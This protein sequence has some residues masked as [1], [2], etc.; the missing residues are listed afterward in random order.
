MPVDPAVVNALSDT[1]LYQEAMAFLHE[2]ANF[3]DGSKMSNSQLVGLLTYSRNWA[4]LMAY[5]KHQVGR[6]WV[7]KAHYALFYRSLLKYLDTPP[8][9]LRM[10][11]K[12]D[13]NLLVKGL[14]RKEER[15]QIYPWA[16]ALAQEFM[17]HLVAQA[18]FQA[19]TNRGH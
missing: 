1:V 17:Q 14:T 13:F 3:A 19:A 7:N 4:E 18:Q 2:H 11:V 10:R 6:D 12:S 16:Q 5:V 8:Q 9:G 15:D